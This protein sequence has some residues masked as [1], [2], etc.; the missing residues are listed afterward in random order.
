MVE[1]IFNIP[2]MG[3]LSFEAVLSRDYPVI[4]GVSVCSATLTLLG[5]LVSDVLYSVVDPRISFE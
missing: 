4:M 3:R 1:S 5:V 2:G